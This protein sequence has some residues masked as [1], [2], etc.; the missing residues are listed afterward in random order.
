MLGLP[1]GVAGIIG[2][3]ELFRGIIKSLGEISCSLVSGASVIAWE[4]S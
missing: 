2:S 3:L 4:I 1:V